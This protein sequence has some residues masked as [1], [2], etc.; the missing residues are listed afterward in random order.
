MNKSRIDFGADFAAPV[1]GISLRS[2]IVSLGKFFFVASVLSAACNRHGEVRPCSPVKAF[3]VETDLKAF[4][5][6]PNAGYFTVYDTASL[7]K[8]EVKLGTSLPHADLGKY[9]MA[10]S[11]GRRFGGIVSDD[12]I[13]YLELLEPDDRADSERIRCYVI[14]F[15]RKWGGFRRVLRCD[16]WFNGNR[17]E[18]FHHFRAPN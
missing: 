7:K 4:D 15:P 3:Y 5:A 2:A 17:I 14:L 9:K 8:A 18:R 13:K 10:C 11:I 12:C 1:F 16:E 6:D